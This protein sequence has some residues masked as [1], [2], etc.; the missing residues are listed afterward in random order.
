MLAGRPA[1]L[2]S[3][4]IA[5][6]VMSGEP[7]ICSSLRLSRTVERPLKPMLIATTPNVTRMKAAT[8]PPISNSLR[9]SHSFVRRF[10]LGWSL[11]GRRARGIRAGAEV[12]CGDSSCLLSEFP[13][14]PGVWGRQTLGVASVTT[15]DV[16]LR[17]GSTLR[18]RPPGP[19]D[20]DAL[21]AF[22]EGLSERSRYLRFHGLP[23]VGRALVEPYL[24]SDWHE[25]GALVGSVGDR[26][27]TLAS[28]ARL[29]DPAAAEVAFAVADDYQGRGV[30]SRLL[31]QLAEAA[32]DAGVERFIAEVML[33][34]G[35]MVR[36]FDEAGFAVAH[37]LEGGT[38][39]VRLE[40]APTEHYREQVDR[41]DHV[42]VTASLRPFFA[43]ASVAV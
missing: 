38:L 6:G 29:R 14:A 9:I 35:R 22:F 27:V 42:A 12:P 21:V 43:P 30:G 28:Y 23:A 18:L 33:E 32:A 24:E 19:A 3:A 39:E 8:R 13:Y 7:T 31:E 15:R 4:A 40:L 37:E 11:E 20:A 1:C 25:R 5:A 16:I 10:V 17:D 34:N 2:A 26:I 41:R 36:V